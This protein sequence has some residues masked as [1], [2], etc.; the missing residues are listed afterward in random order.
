MEIYILKSTAC[1][2]ILFL[3][4]KLVLENSSLHTIKRFFLLGSLT[5]S[6][7]IPFITF[8]EYVEVA[9][10]VT[11]R[12][13]ESSVTM[14]EPIAARASP[15][16]YLPYILSGIYV[17]GALIFSVR[18]GRNMVRIFTKVKRNQTLKKQSIF[19]VLL[20]HPVTPHSFFNYIFFGK[21]AYEASEIPKEV[22]VHETAHVAQ[23]HSWDIVFFE[24][25]RI[26]FWFNP[27]LYFLK[28]SI[29][30]NHEFL[31]DRTV[32]NEGSE[33][34]R[35]QTILLD[36]SSASSVPAM[37]HS[38][39]YSSIKKRF[40]VMNTHTSKRAAWLKGLLVLPLL[41]VLIYGFS[42]TQIVEKASENPTIST[43]KATPKQI[44]IYNQL[45]KKYNAVP[46]SERKIGWEDLK[47]LEN[48][49]RFMNTAQKQNALPFPECLAKNKIS[50]EKEY[51][52]E[53]NIGAARN[54]NKSIV[55]T[56]N[57]SEIMVNGKATTLKN[58]AKEIDRATKG[59]KT[60]DYK[61]AYPSV[62]V[63]ATPDS[64]MEKLDAEF[65]KTEYFKS[66]G[67]ESIIP[68]TPPPPPSPMVPGSPY[69]PKV[70]EGENDN[71][72]NI[73]P[74]PPAPKVIKGVNDGPSNIPPPPPPPNPLDHIIEMAKKGA[75][76]YYDG[77]QIS[78]DK[79]IEIMQKNKGL[80]IQ[81]TRSGSKN[82]QVKISKKPIKVDS[83]KNMGKINAAEQFQ[84]T[85]ISHTESIKY[86]KQLAQEGAV[87]YW[88]PHTI[89]AN[90]ALEVLQK[91]NKL[92]YTVNNDGFN[93]PVVILVGC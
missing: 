20:K 77:N 23:K 75:T 22:L 37:A 67:G 18:F 30:L 27:L 19:H 29:K 31:A 90:A 40:T 60:A 35:Y 56:I 70:I 48:T 53:Y 71:A 2:G 33:L 73:P 83:N 10:M 68:T 57:V 24:V 92:S 28:N 81:T 86:A 8:M 78:S 62:L 59:W 55:I 16:N 1:L 38:I 74:P 41:A 49:Y 9:P 12:F 34:S 76:F 47:T 58:F 61:A 80:N 66:N 50:W 51:A 25:F 5:V 4:Y 7:L 44:E 52:K 46:I 54:N 43:E 84:S 93:K 87:F 89:T 36:F 63:A 39:N 79:A 21:T 32:L 88:G 42:N 45:A 82:P 3:F 64:F 26:I 85:I 13:T 14:A 72:P 69:A 17:L 65:R 6:L 91:D 11:Q 15:L